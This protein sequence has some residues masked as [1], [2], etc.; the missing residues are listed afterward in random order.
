MTVLGDGERPRLESSCSSDNGEAYPA[1]RLAYFAEQFPSNLVAS[2]CNADLSGAIASA[3]TAM[4]NGLESEPAAY[5]VPSTGA[6]NSHSKP[7]LGSDVPATKLCP[8]I[9]TC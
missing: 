2:I 9:A 3:G 1:H 6:L 5:A 7:A 8:H 4:R